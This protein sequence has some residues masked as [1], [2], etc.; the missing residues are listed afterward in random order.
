V[1]FAPPPAFDAPP[2]GRQW[3]TYWIVFAFFNLTEAMTGFFTSHIPFYFFIKLGFLIFCMSDQ[4]K[5]AQVVYQKVIKPHVVD[6]FMAPSS[7][8]AD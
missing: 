4:H 8:K 6:R 5:G 1:L 3:L 2:G 7:E